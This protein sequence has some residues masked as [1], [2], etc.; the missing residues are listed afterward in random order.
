M[1]IAIEDKSADHV[2]IATDGRFA[3]RMMRRNHGIREL[4]QSA[5]ENRIT[6]SPK[7]PKSRNSKHTPLH[8]NDGRDDYDDSSSWNSWSSSNCSTSYAAAPRPAVPSELAESQD[9][10]PPLNSASPLELAEPPKS[11]ASHSPA[12]SLDFPDPLNSAPPPESVA[13]AHTAP[14]AQA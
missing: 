5:C 11:A 4:L 10:A 3:R 7:T 9:P 2:H 12:P 1:E 6:Q 14:P 8:L 13:R